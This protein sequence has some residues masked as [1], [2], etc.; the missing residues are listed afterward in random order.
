MFKFLVLLPF[1]WPVAAVALGLGA[2]YV[3]A[4]HF[5]AGLCRYWGIDDVVG[6]G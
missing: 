5:L 1:I 6:L 3:S 4:A 2:A